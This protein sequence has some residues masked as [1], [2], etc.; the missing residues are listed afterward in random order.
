MIREV[1]LYDKFSFCKNGVKCMK[2]HLKEVCQNRECDYRMCNKRH[3]RPC[4]IFSINGFCRFGTS[5]RY[6]HRPSKEMEE[7]NK[8]IE[9][10]NQNIESLR[11]TT[12]KLSKQVADQN[13]ELK[14][15]KKKLLEIERRD[16]KR[17]QEQ[18]DALL[19]T[20]NEKEK[21]INILKD[22]KDNLKNQNVSGDEDVL[23]NKNIV[24]QGQVHV[25]SEKAIMTEEELLMEVEV[26]NDEVHVSVEEA[27]V[28][29]ERCE[30]EE[31]K[32]ATIEYAQK[33]LTHVEKL[34][35]KIKKIKKNAPDLGTSLMTECKQFCE[36]LDGIEVN[37]E[38]C[39]DVLEK[40]DNLREYLRYA[41]RKPEKIRNLNSIV[42]CKKY[43]KGYLKYPK[44]PH[45][46]PTNNCCKSCFQ[47]L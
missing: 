16:L 15:L 23:N 21:V 4:R 17:L 13:D 3:P 18:V 30:A 14:G 39:E 25:V 40:V 8:V 45:Q 2:V 11:V 47:K 31:I 10:Q 46:I 27:E 36:R 33:C 1:C 34:E 28:N 22:L 5:C 35:V 44:R 41:D 24:I 42:A 32:K 43:L 26:K 12:S 7:Q 20:N 19:Q 37:E 29:E 38:L 9:K 6:S